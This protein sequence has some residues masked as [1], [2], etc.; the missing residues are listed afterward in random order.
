MAYASVCVAV[1]GHLMVTEVFFRDVY[2][3]VP[4]KV[5]FVSSRVAASVCVHLLIDT[6]K[7]SMPNHF[8][9]SSAPFWAAIL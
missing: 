9:N 1:G 8:E 6:F 2:Q 3:P 4:C 7:A 5:S